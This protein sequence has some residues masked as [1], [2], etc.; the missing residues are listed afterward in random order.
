MAYDEELAE[1]I[2]AALDDVKG[3][4][5]IKMFGGLCFTVGGNMAVGVSHDDL[6]VRLLPDDGDAALTEPGVR[7]MEIGSRTSRGFL[8]VAPEA[9]RTDLKLHA[10]VDRGVAFASSLPPKKP[11]SNKR[12]PAKP[13]TP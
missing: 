11:K 13:R 3:V 1:R 9:T 4:A 2:R 6:L 12:K 5:E 7:L 8:S 10:W